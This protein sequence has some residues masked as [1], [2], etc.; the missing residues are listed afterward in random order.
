MNVP[1]HAAVGLGADLIARLYGSYARRIREIVSNSIDA[2]A[3]NFYMN[4]DLSVPG[5]KITFLD[6]GSGMSE[7]VILNEFL[8]IGGSRKRS[9]PTKIGRIGIGFLAMA[10]LG[11][12]IKIQTRSKS[13]TG[14]YQEL[15]L[16][17]NVEELLKE[18]QRTQEIGKL[19]IA[20]LENHITI[21]PPFDTFTF[22][23]ITNLTRAFI[24]YLTD[25]EEQLV[26]ELRRILPLPYT[27]GCPL[28]KHLEETQEGKE[29]ISYLRGLKTISFWYRDKTILNRLAYYEDGL[30]IF[31]KKTPAEI[32]HI[33]FLDKY[34]PVE[35]G[36]PIHLKGYL[37]LTNSNVKEPWRGF[38]TRVKNIAVEE[39]GWLN[40]PPGHA[41]VRVRLTGELF[42]D[43]LDDNKAINMDRTAFNYEFGEVIDI[44]D[45]LENWVPN[46]TQ[47][48]KDIKKNKEK[49]KNASSVNIMDQKTDQ[50]EDNKEDTSQDQADSGST[51]SSS[52][53]DKPCITFGSNPERPEQETHE[54][55]K[56]A[57]EPPA[58]VTVETTNKLDIETEIKYK[59]IT[60]KIL[61]QPFDNKSKLGD[62]LRDKK[63]IYLNPNHPL[64]NENTS[65]IKEISA[66]MLLLQNPSDTDKINDSTKKEI[67][68]ATEIIINSIIEGIGSS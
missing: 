16:K 25:K 46:Y 27:D 9:D 35:T 32:W 23:E 3:K 7:D 59:G 53:G 38:V 11:H 20:D 63:Y 22:I 58:K 64:L 31:E 15:T 26:F 14:V 39:F 30:D 67:C 24:K 55:D 60:W 41:V 52:V 5:G 8:N 36:D 49:R 37:I 43:G 62:V 13:E 28:F 2:G 12:S 17:V 51:P 21:S 44:L 40:R 61:K 68:E 50:K 66:F 47:V 48:N 19:N 33:Y 10:G 65:N 45:C 42:I 57:T 18:S 56:T 29:L 54:E 34:I 6:D 4:F 1:L